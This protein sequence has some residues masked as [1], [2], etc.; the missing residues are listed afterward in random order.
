MANP[1]QVASLVT[2]LTAARERH[3]AQAAREAEERALVQRAV[4]ERRLLLKS[5][6]EAASFVTESRRSAIAMEWAPYWRAA[7]RAWS[8]YGPAD[9]FKSARIPDLPQYQIAFTIFKL[10][11]EDVPL[12]RLQELLGEVIDELWEHDTIGALRS[13]LSDLRSAA[14]SAPLVTSIEDSASSATAQ[15]P[16]ASLPAQRPDADRATQ[17]VAAD[18][19]QRPGGSVLPLESVQRIQAR[20][21]R[22]EVQTRC[23]LAL[24]RLLALDR[25]WLTSNDLETCGIPTTTLHCASTSQAW[26]SDARG[27]GSCQKSY[28]RSRVVTWVEMSWVPRA[29]RSI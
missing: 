1:S 18:G 21:P 13:F 8:A 29:R 4:Q 23:L 11:Q 5:I 28:R 15:E 25:E 19:R 12:E 14:E 3:A 16:N 22:A 24:E 20:L 10:A 26:G 2:E 6:D 9:G 7:A 27:T 17:P